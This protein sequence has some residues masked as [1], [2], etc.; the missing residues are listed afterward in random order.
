MNTKQKGYISIE[1]VVAAAVLLLLST[2]LYV[3]FL[4]VPDDAD[5]ESY[6]TICLGGFEYWRADLEF[7]MVLA[8]KLT[9]QGL[10]V[11]CAG[12]Q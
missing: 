8:S 6:V 2:I 11:V 10:P 5:P 12:I 4:Y 1:F 3:L 9:A 7:G